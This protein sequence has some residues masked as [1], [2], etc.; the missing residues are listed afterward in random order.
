MGG[1]VC[2]FMDVLEPM[3]AGSSTFFGSV[4]LTVP[5][6]LLLYKVLSDGV[7]VGR[8]Y[9]AVRHTKEG[10]M[11]RNGKCRHGENMWNCHV[12]KLRCQSTHTST[13]GTEKGKKGGKVFHLGK[14]GVNVC[15]PFI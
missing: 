8:R 6:M 7:G 2:I 3:A 4:E 12:W 13:Y 10:K 5:A 9:T 11:R 15:L 1:K 14:I